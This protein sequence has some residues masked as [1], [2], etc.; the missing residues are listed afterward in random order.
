MTTGLLTR[1][2]VVLMKIEGTYGVD[3]VPVVA[4]DAIRVFDFDWKFANQKMVEQKDASKN[5][6]GPN[7]QIHA[8]KLVQV[9]FKMPIKGSG[10]IDVAP[11]LGVPLRCCRWAETVN[12]A[13]SVVY[14]PSSTTS[15]SGGM[16]FQ[17]DGK[18]YVFLGMRGTFKFMGNSNDAGWIEFTIDGHFG[19]HTDTALGSPTLDTTEPPVIKSAGFTLDAYAAAIN[20]LEFDAGNVI[21]LPLDAN[22]ADGYGEIQIVDFDIVGSINPLDVLIGTNDFIDDWETSKV[23]A[24]TTGVIGSVAGNRWQLAMDYVSTRDITPE[25]SD[26]LRRFQLAFGAHESAGDDQASLTFT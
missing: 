16:Y 26:E 7:K 20:A 19:A 14:A 12:V 4:T 10:T 5:T 11:E 25:R 2:K 8:D 15:A 13:T 21:V 18:Q 1:R 22:A 17:E 23:M 6:L 24:L 3:P 9:T